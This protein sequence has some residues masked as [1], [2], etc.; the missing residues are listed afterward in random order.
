MKTKLK[1]IMLAIFVVSTY[2][3]GKTIPVKEMGDAKYLV[4]KAESVNAYEYANEKY[5]AARKALFDAHEHVS[6]GNMADARKKAEQSQKLAQEAF[7]L[8]VPKLA[9]ATRE[10]A[11]RVLEEADSLFAAEFAQ[12]AFKNSSDFLADGRQHQKE[13]K[14]EEAYLKFESAR[15]EATKARSIAE[16]Q[17]ES[18]KNELDEVTDILAEAEKNGSK[19]KFP[20]DHQKA[21]KLLKVA[22][23]QFEGKNIKGSSASLQEARTIA[24]KLLN[25]SLAEKAKKDFQEASKYVGEVKVNYTS[26]KSQIKSYP[27][28]QKYFSEDPEATEISTAIETTL[29]AAE[30]SLS[31]ARD[32][33]DNRAYSDS[34]SQSEEAKRLAK[35]VDDQI[36]QIIVLAKD[37]GV[38]LKS[39]SSEKVAGLPSEGDDLL[40]PGWKKYKVR[41]LPARR[42][43]LWRIAG[44]DYIYDEPRLWTKIYKANK[45]K[46][47]NPDLI[48]P[49]QVFEIPP[50]SGSIT[51]TKVETTTVPIVDQTPPQ[52]EEDGSEEQTTSQEGEANLEERDSSYEGKEEAEGSSEEQIPSQ[53]EKQG[54]SEEQQDSTEEE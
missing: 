3:C 18:L 14:H 1:I 40:P 10:E 6:K 15:E 5:E 51:K 27:K 17:V 11:E 54:D 32:S 23:D 37:Q 48:F 34:T 46:I 20:Q 29:N 30:E 52:E 31:L 13:N 44:Y 4:S 35:I 28:L 9:Q 39:L 21:Q 41:Y 16:I 7:D 42:D 33:L 26:L 45:S 38:I 49:G 2:Q 43:C 22:K 24:E 19:E 36:P 25:D 47:K 50:K 8:S 53:E 12:E